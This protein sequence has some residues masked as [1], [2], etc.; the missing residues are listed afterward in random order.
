MTSD[1]QFG[2]QKYNVPAKRGSRFE[3]TLN[4]VYAHWPAFASL[5]GGIVLALVIIGVSA[6]QGW[7]GLIPLSLA[8]II[9][10]TYF[11]LASLWSM[12]L[13]FD[14]DGFNAHHILFEMGQI[15]AADTLVCVDL[16]FRRRAIDIVQRL[17]TGKAIVID[18][19]NPQWNPNRALARHRARMPLP[20]NDP[21]L[22]WRNGRSDMLPLPDKSVTAVFLCQVLSEFWQEGD[23]LQLLQEVYRVLSENGRLLMAEQMRTPTAWLFK[24]PAALSLAPVEEWRDLLQKA[25][26]RLRTEQDLQGIIHCIRADKPTYTEA[27]QLTLDI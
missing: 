19:Y 4:A 23:R 8:I 12:H 15:Q 27:Q 25:G 13:Q 16:G 20:P 24:G 14:R 1:H 10:L 3:G 5:Y 7:I 2:Q 9:V 21:R 11:F 26:F 18:V 17:T 6:E 22:I